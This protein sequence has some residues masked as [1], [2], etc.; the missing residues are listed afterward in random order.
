MNTAVASSASADTAVRSAAAQDGAP[1]RSPQEQ[2]ADLVGQATDPRTGRLDT[3]TL[4]GWVAD[5][6]RRDPAAAAQA[7]AAIEQHLLDSGRPGDL[8]RFN[9]DVV[10]AASQSVPG[11]AGLA[12]AGQGMLQRGTQLLVDN[13]ILVK[14][15]ENTPSAWT[16][17]SGFSSGLQD[18]LARHG[19][20]FDPNSVNPVPPGSITKTPGVPV[21]QANNLNGQLAEQA[22]RDRYQA[23]GLAVEPGPVARADGAR[24]VD[25]VVH[26]PAN[27]PRMHERIEIESKVGYR[28]SGSFI[29]NQ[30]ANDAADLASNRGIRQAGQVLEGAGKVL[31]PVGLVLDAIE[32]GQAFRADGNRV[33]EGTARAASGVAGGALGGWGGA[34]GGAAIGTMIMPGVGTVVGGIIGGIAGAMGGDAAGRGLF[35][36]V[37]SWF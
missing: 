9:Q 34:V 5:A 11:P 23:A 31:R 10:A 12:G 3:R 29:R 18:L 19:I 32:V 7:H 28:T 26:K 22:I 21:Q 20:E 14:R 35:D 36:T 33:G 15:W 37:K 2:A 8:S 27:D 30:I 25:V 24:V 1:P 16:H 13:P 4:G 6:A 17:K